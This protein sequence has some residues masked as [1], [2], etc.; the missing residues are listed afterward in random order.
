MEHEYSNLE[1]GLRDYV[2]LMNRERKHLVCG[3][4]EPNYV[5]CDPEALTLTV[6]YASKLWEQNPDGVLHGGIVATML[7]TVIGTLTHIITGKLTPTVSLN[8]SYLRPAP[9]DGVIV[10]KAYV[11]KMGRTLIHTRGEAW[12]EKR[13]EKLI[14]TAEAVYRNMA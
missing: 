4:M 3:M 2:D 10:I 8:I 11:T 1:Q 6:S 5:A 13:P 9:G 14:A 7:D 12:E